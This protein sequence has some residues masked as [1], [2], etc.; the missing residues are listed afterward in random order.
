MPNGSRSGW[1]DCRSGCL[2]FRAHEFP[3]A[4]STH[5]L[6]HRPKPTGERQERAGLDRGDAGGFAICARAIPPISNGGS[7]IFFAREARRDL[8]RRSRRHAA[9]IGRAPIAD[10]LAGHVEPMGILFGQRAR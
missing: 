7:P 3:C 8:E 2:S 10:L 1:R 4:A 5:K 9:P 6:R